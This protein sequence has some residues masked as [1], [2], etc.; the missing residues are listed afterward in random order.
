MTERTPP[1][2][3]SPA[4][5]TSLSPE[6]LR[7]NKHK[8]QGDRRRAADRERHRSLRAKGKARVDAEKAAI[9]DKLAVYSIKGSRGVVRP[10]VRE[11]I[12]T[13]I[14][15]GVPQTKTFQVIDAV[16]N[17]GGIGVDGKFDVHT[18]RRIIAEGLVHSEYQA[19]DAMV[20]AP[21][22]YSLLYTRG[23]Y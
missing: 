14:E 15:L 19:V 13:L 23:P 22:Q 4:T 8:A 1:S 17:N 11:L 3:P 9:F 5:T 16:L 12:R 20:H 2:K 6:S 21:S 10:E 18:A 7:T